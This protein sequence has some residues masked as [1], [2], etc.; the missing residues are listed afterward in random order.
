[1]CYFSKLE[2]IAKNKNTVKTTL[3][4]ARQAL[5]LSWLDFRP[6]RVTEIPPALTGPCTD[7]DYTSESPSD[8]YS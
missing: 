4:H 1:M 2:H 6:G 3:L 7:S 5:L 8:D